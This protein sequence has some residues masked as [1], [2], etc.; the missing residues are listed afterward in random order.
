MVSEGAMR[1]TGPSSL[2]V[3]STENGGY[4]DGILEGL[5]GMGIPTS[6]WAYFLT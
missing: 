2:A 5:A 3:V 4:R 6:L 1:G